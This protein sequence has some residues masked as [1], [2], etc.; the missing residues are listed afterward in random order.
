MLSNIFYFSGFM[1]LLLNLLIFSKFKKYVYV[2]EFLE[3]FQKVTGNIPKKSDYSENN[4]EFINFV[5]AVELLNSFWFFLGLIGANWL[6]FLLFFV[7]FSL[8]TLLIKLIKIKFLSDSLIFLKL[9]FVVFTLSLLVFNHYHFHLNLTQI[10][11][12]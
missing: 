5:L 2:K 7:I 10:F 11:L 12:K 4:F 3:K 1:L 9:T 6:V 8:I